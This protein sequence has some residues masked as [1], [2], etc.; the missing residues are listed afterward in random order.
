MAQYNQRNSCFNA[1]DLLG[2]VENKSYTAIVF[3]CSQLGIEDLELLYNFLVYM[4][5]DHK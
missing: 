2:Y 5:Q 4:S 1:C 3:L